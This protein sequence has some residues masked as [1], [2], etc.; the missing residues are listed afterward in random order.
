[1]G[2]RTHDL[3][4]KRHILNRFNKLKNAIKKQTETLEPTG[5]Y[6]Y[7]DVVKDAMAGLILQEN[8]ERILERENEINKLIRSTNRELS[9]DEIDILKDLVRSRKGD[10]Y[11]IEIV[12]FRKEK[13]NNGGAI[14]PFS[15]GASVTYNNEGSE[16]NKRVIKAHELGHIWLHPDYYTDDRGVPRRGLIPPEHRKLDAP[17]THA[18]IF[19]EL[20]M[21]HRNE[22]YRNHP[23]KFP[24]EN[25]SFHKSLVLSEIEALFPK[26]NPKL[27]PE[28]T[29]ELE[30]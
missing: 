23:N 14:H 15:G 28:G 25:K 18:Y 11:E 13:M 24:L 1:M 12:P 7:F 6:K 22:I 17:E 8:R 30:E 26:Y 19:A 10:T 29:E 27:I 20:L 2:T 21:E 9:S 3:I 16:L 5:N 4:S